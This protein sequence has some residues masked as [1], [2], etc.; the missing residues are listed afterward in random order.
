MQDEKGYSVS[1]FE[2]K[3]D[4]IFEVIMDNIFLKK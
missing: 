3:R 4:I 1:F 2:I